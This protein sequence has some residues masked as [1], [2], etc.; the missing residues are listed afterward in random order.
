MCLSS[1]K[2]ISGGCVFA[3]IVE[4]E[5]GVLGRNIMERESAWTPSGLLVRT[6]VGF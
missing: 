5:C 2:H 6:R 4:M 1:D 3:H